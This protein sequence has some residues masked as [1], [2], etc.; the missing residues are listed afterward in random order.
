MQTYISSSVTETT[1]NRKKFYNF[2]KEHNYK[3]SY[4]NG[5][6]LYYRL[7]SEEKETALN[8]FNYILNLSFNN[9]EIYDLF[10]MLGME[11]T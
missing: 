11:C 3:I 7:F 4:N 10:N 8:I 1:E 6:S 5:G 9:S 2:G